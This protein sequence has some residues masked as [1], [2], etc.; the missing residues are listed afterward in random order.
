MITTQARPAV[1]PTQAHR[2]LLAGL[3]AWTRKHWISLAVIGGLLIIV[4]A[5][6]AWNLMG[7]PLW[8]DD[9]QGTYVAQ[10]RAVIMPSHHI[11][12]YTYW[13]DHTPGGWA[14]MGVYFWVTDALGRY[15]LA[16]MA[17]REFMWEINLVGSAALYVLARRLNMRRASAAAAVVLFG[18]SPLAI[19]YHRMVFLDNIATVFLLVALALAASPRR[20]LGTVIGGAACMSAAFWSKET[21][22]LMVPA[23]LWIVWRHSD[24]RHRGFWVAG[25]V[26]F[27]TSVV[28]YPLFALLRN[29]LFPGKGHVSLIWSL[30]WQLVLRPP[31]GSL[32]N[33]HSGTYAEALTWVHLDPW[34]VLGGLSL[35]AAAVFIRRLWPFVL[36]MV[37]T[38]AIPIKGGY[39]PSAYIT[40][41]LPFLGLIIAGVGD[42]W[43]SPIQR[44]ISGAHRR[45]GFGPQAVRRVLPYVGRVPVAAAVLVFAILVAPAWGRFFVAQSH[46]NGATPTMVAEA[47]VEHHVPKND[48]VIVNDD[49]W[50][51]LKMH[52]GV[53]PVWIWKVDLDPAVM[54]KIL[55]DGWRSIDYIAWAPKSLGGIQVI[56]N[57]LPTMKQALAHSV[58]VARCGDGITIDK[59]ITSNK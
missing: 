47:W 15:P 37:I 12:H 2:S 34:L 14:L 23:W 49:M 28:G 48:V 54:A 38:V 42:T 3:R 30:K 19:F 24:R 41:A 35:T 44:F 21:V 58:V 51:D 9:D 16:V 36:A 45:N 17:G 50:A 6:N 56:L 8:H 20:S 39:V 33:T 43:W 57:Q 52:S 59:V 25:A 40:V 26:F 11:A 18:L 22:A 29:E 1:P 13:Y 27:L 7:W 10:A 31:T 53:L 46:V 55:P 5:A 4:A 32:L